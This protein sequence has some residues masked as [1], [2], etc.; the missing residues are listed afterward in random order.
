MI[1]IGMSIFVSGLSLFLI[2][3]IILFVKNIKTRALYKTALEQVKEAI[4]LAKQSSRAKDEFL[5]KMS[6]EIRTPM[7]AIIG[8][9]ELALREDAL[10]AAR[11]H[12]ITVKQAGVNLLSIINDI[13]DLSRI[14]SGDMKII[15]VNYFL[16]SLLND[17]ISI[18]RMKTVDS[19]L[20]FAVNV[21]SN[22]PNALI[23]DE[24]RIRQI[25]I[26][27]LGNAVKFTNDG[28]VFLRIHGEIQEEKIVM[29]KIEVE[30]SG[31]G[32]KQ[33][34]ME[35]LFE[36][37]FQID[38][39]PS[40][41]KGVGLGLA[42][43]RNIVLAMGGDISVQSEYGKGSTFTVI[44]PQKIYNRKKLAAVENPE[45]KAAIVFERRRVYA[46]SIAYAINN[47]DVKCKHVANCEEFMAIISE[48][49]FPFIFVSY[50]LFKK[51]KK[52]L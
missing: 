17:V 45:E 13:L 43:T 28:Y 38:S 16:S 12:L 15:S 7:N 52:R 2:V 29:L 25:L 23:G 6:H 8:M 35:K 21:D 5:A 11:E 50:D 14:E 3:L 46:D 41:E 39:A 34:D 44:L 40:N 37:Y 18:I 9:I 30:D 4:E 36:N 24:T 31:R 22:I 51:T 32:I 47:L 48:E 19:P 26:N 20:R 33:E 1:Y 49:S 42:I 10:D 27:L